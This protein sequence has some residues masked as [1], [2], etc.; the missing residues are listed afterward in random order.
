MQE[1]CR[2]I[3][4]E[5]WQEYKKLKELC[6]QTVIKI[7]ANGNCE[8][9][10]FG[11]G[12][13]QVLDDDLPNTWPELV[14]W[15]KQ[16]GWESDMRLFEQG[17]LEMLSKDTTNGDLFYFVEPGHMWLSGC[18]HYGKQLSIKQMAMIIKALGK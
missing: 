15:A 1:R 17:Y 14:E 12:T 3:T 9:I 8:E 5:Q 11:A 4:L 13:I 18:S 6:E 10:Q 2:L 7:D 16:Y